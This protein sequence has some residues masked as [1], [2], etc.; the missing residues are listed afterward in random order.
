MLGPPTGCMSSQVTA[1][2]SAEHTFRLNAGGLPPQVCLH[3]EVLG[4][5]AVDPPGADTEPHESLHRPAVVPRHDVHLNQVPPKA[6]GD[7]APAKDF[8]P[9]SPPP[10]QF[11]VLLLGCCFYLH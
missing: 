2:P 1:F 4:R 9:G 5:G 8:E 7:R 6:A 3:D 11:L 10:G